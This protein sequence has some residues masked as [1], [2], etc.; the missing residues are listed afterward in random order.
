MRRWWNRE[1]ARQYAQAKH[2]YMTADSGGANG[3]R[4]YQWKWE[5]Q[6]LANETGLTIHVSHYPSGTS[7]WNKVEHRLLCFIAKNW[8]GIPL[9]T[10]EI[11]LGLIEGTKT[12]KGLSVKA[13]L[14][15]GEYE[16]HKK[17]TK[18]QMASIKIKKHKFHPEWNYSIYPNQ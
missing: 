2:L 10:Y 17:P 8:Q 16:L 11:I 1:G 18:E 7:K 15:T 5:L 13:E 3:N 9:Q 4:V 6:Q 12:K 14:D